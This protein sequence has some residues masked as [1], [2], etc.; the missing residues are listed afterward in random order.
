MLVAVC[1]LNVCKENGVIFKFV[2]WLS[3]NFYKNYSLTP[4][5][6]LLSGNVVMSSICTA[7]FDSPQT[8][9]IS[10][11]GSFQLIRYKLSSG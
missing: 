7:G 10:K 3:R 1:L 9:F 4:D 6:S 2:Y 5:V 8:G 11:L